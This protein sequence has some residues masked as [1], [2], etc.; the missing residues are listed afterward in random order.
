MGSTAQREEKRREEYEEQNWREE[1][2]KWEG[3]KTK[4]NGWEG[5]V[6]LL[7]PKSLNHYF[8]LILEDKTKLWSV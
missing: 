6:T 7:R 1:N 3:M 8:E 5:T 4:E 2:E